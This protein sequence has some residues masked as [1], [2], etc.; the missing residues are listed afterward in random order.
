MVKDNAG[1]SASTN[2]IPWAAAVVGNGNDAD[3][4]VSQPVN[5]GIGE[6]MERQRP[7]VVHTTFTKCG[8]LV[9]KV[10]C[11]IKLL[12]EIFRRNKRAFADIPIDHCIG[13]GLRLGAKADSNRFWRHGF[14]REDAPSL[15]QRESI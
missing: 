6:A 14:L 15:H 1:I 4:I 8:E 11:A 13:V 5:Q 3:S 9:E 10:E 12:G 7:R 2:P